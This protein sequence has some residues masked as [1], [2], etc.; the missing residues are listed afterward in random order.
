MLRAHLRA[1]PDADAHAGEYRSGVLGFTGGL[2]AAVVAAGGAGG[3]GASAELPLAFEANGG[4]YE[5]QVR[6]VGRDAG[7]VVAL[8]DRGADVGLAAGG[9]VALR[10]AGARR[11]VRVLGAGRRQG[12]V[13]D[14]RAGRTGIPAWS[15]VRFRRPWRGIDVVFHGRRKTLEYDIEVAPHADPRDA[16]I[17]VSG[18][19]PVV[20]PDGSLAIRTGHGTLVQRAPVAWQ[21]ERRV[22]VRYVVR[23]R[24]LGFAVG[25]YD[26]SRRLVI[27]PVVQY[28]TYLGGTGFDTADGLAVDATGAAYV[29]GTTATPDWLGLAPGQDTQ[30]GGRDIVLTKLAPAGTARVY[31]TLLGGTED[32]AG[33]GL[34][35]RSVPGPSGAEIQPVLVGST[36]SG[37]SFPGAPDPATPAGPHGFV[38]ALRAD[39]TSVASSRLV[40]SEYGATDLS[41][42][43]V[44]SDGTTV[45][46]AGTT[47]APTL[48]GATGTLSGPS[49]AVVLRLTAA[50]LAATPAAFA[51]LGGTGEDL[52][53]GVTAL[54]D[55]TVVAGQSTSPTLPG[56]TPGSFD[57]TRGGAQDGFVLRLSGTTPT[58]TFLGGA[59]DGDALHDLVAD[60]TGITVVG[61]TGSDGLATPG[62]ADGTLDGS[63]DGVVARLAADLSS[64]AW[65]TYVGGPFA[66]DAYGIARGAAGGYWVAGREE[67]ERA[68]D[69]L[70]VREPHAR[71]W[72]L[73]GDGTAVTRTIDVGGRD[74]F[75]VAHH[76]DT[77]PAGNAYVAGTTVNGGDATPGAP[78]SEVQGSDDLFLAKLDGAAPQTSITD[79]PAGEVQASSVTFTFTADEPATFRCSLD[80]ADLGPC[81]S[82]KQVTVQPG[83]HV[84]AVTATDEAG[85]ADATPAERGFTATVAPEP[86][87]AP[88]PGA[89][90][91]STPPG[92]SLVLPFAAVLRD[93]RG[94]VP[95][96]PLVL[97]ASASTGTPPLRFSWDLDGDGAFE[98]GPQEDPRRQHVF[99]EPGDRRVSVRVT[100]AS[101]RVT[102]ASALVTVARRLRMTPKLDVKGRR[103]DFA[104]G[105]TTDP[106]FPV[107]HYVYDFGDGSAPRTDRV[108][109]GGIAF[110]NVD[111]GRDATPSHRYAKDGLYRWSITAV[112]TNGDRH[113]VSGGVEVETGRPKDRTGG[114][115]LGS[116]LKKNTMWVA[117]DG[118]PDFGGGDIIVAG[119]DPVEYRLEGAPARTT[120]IQVDRNTP[121]R[122]VTV[123]GGEGFWNMGDGSPVKTGF[124]VLHTYKTKKDP[125]QVGS[126]K[127][128]ASARASAKKQTPVPATLPF[129]PV[130]RGVVHFKPAAYEKTIEEAIVPFAVRPLAAV[131]T[132]LRLAGDATARGA[133][134]SCLYPSG[135]GLYRTAAGASLLVNGLEVRPAEADGRIW[136]S[137]D[138]TIGKDKSTRFDVIADPTPK[139]GVAG[140]TIARGLSRFTIPGPGSGLREVHGLTGPPSSGENIR[141]GGLRVG[142]RTVQVT[143]KGRMRTTLHSILPA[144]FGAE[145]APITFDTA[146]QTVAGGSIHAK[147]GQPIEVV[148][149]DMTFG[150][151]RAY[152]ILL[153]LSAEHVLEGGG[154]LEIFENKILAPHAKPDETKQVDIGGG[155][156][157]TL[158]GPSGFAVD[159]GIRDDSAP[160]APKFLYGGATFVPKKPI[161][162]GP[163]GVSRIVLGVQTDPFFLKGQITAEAPIS[164]PI[165][166][167]DGCVQIQKVEKGQRLLLC[168]GDVETLEECAQR[169]DDRANNR[170]LPETSQ[171]FFTLYD[172][173]EPELA[174]ALGRA[175][176]P[177]EVCAS[178]ASTSD[179][180]QF[181]LRIGAEVF[182]K[183]G[184][185]S[186]G[187]GFFEYRSGGGGSVHFGGYANASFPGLSLKGSVEGDFYFE[188]KF[189]WQIFA[190]I[191]A[192]ILGV[193]AGAQVIV[194]NDLIAAC[195]DVDLLLTEAAIGGGVRWDSGF[196]GIGGF[197]QCD[198]KT[199]YGIQPKAT[200]ASAETM[201]RQGTQPMGRSQ[202]VKSVRG[203]PDYVVFRVDAAN[204]TLPRIKVTG[205][206]FEA[207]DPGPSGAPGARSLAAAG[208]GRVKFLHFER[209]A[210]PG[211]APA[212]VVAIARP[213]AGDYTIT[214]LPEG[215]AIG[216]VSQSTPIP[217]PKVTAKV[218][219]RGNGVFE[220]RTTVPKPQRGEAP[221]K[222]AIVEDARTPKEIRQPVTPSGAQI[223]PSAG[224]T[225]LDTRSDATAEIV[226]NAGYGT[227]SHFFKP[228][229]G[230]GGTRHLYA[231]IVR[232]DTPLPRMPLGSYAAPAP[233]A[234]RAPQDAELVRK[235]SRLE[236]DWTDVPDAAQYVVTVERGDGAVRSYTL[237]GRPATRKKVS[238][239]RRTARARTAAKQ[240]G[241]KTGGKQVTL[242]V[243]ED[244]VKGLRSRLTVKGVP[245]SEDVTVRIRAVDVH[246]RESVPELVKAGPIEVAP[247]PIAG[248]GGGTKPPIGP[249]KGV[250]GT[251]P[252]GQL[253][254]PSN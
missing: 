54:G 102:D 236:I 231:V 145:T 143:G 205:P 185:M 160:V 37:A 173:Q 64:R 216:A 175:P 203:K 177:E 73:L 224:G 222:V 14:L 41:A 147:L 123:K 10:L 30:P 9:R 53:F 24:E 21:G 129:D 130:Y 106:R 19:R 238:I 86:P 171:P 172:T 55:D 40:A 196:F 189:L 233:P 95:N 28:Q 3:T 27:D 249:V 245:E 34:A 61:T 161:A 176:K 188:P 87:P 107:D 232:G 125:K 215:G 49:D 29:L 246:L 35:L 168:K 96:E 57:S 62:A 226:A 116:T 38:L 18:G 78:Q 184:K 82:P 239:G 223:L 83:G 179:Y 244:V 33:G 197:E 101:G 210:A 2:I 84:F 104:L 23:G 135:D 181:W 94:A 112:A 158:S 243:A 32:D 81:T 211:E 159:T 220:L 192:N 77:D 234:V 7:S 56:M 149:P 230:P 170:P 25:P 164:A 193:E 186:L 121:P 13:H 92:P 75:D 208:G 240:T 200:L 180:D 214:A 237:R 59:A 12:V 1:S 133:A 118:D 42:V 138:G 5:E 191:E 227:R 228:A 187:G 72:R 150:P 44:G 204:G 151:V 144:P 80:G 126:S 89:P 4:R 198:L 142:G 52:A 103:V 110:R 98:V 97:D 134:G 167:L 219:P 65:A 58:S 169:I 124:S 128:V 74:G 182:L 252:A 218:I 15:R 47:S 20:R 108:R 99:A 105:T 163:V 199:D 17:R 26:R 113:T 229:H 50:D 235:G 71:A 111:V 140:Q 248:Y 155:K 119:D 225:K 250:P 136:V 154:F 39:G 148:L 174:K 247:V 115:A 139:D 166:D 183:G 241:A 31:S 22:P 63:R 202:A 16:R 51:L 114:V 195:I 207:V 120:T 43:A 60:A 90:P 76:V 146:D 66:D 213:A 88:T 153:E 45:H 36:A 79:G 100:D 190:N 221:L 254:A 201:L 117:T 162:L 165:V 70:P 152:D 132:G 141:L 217:D 127:G 6:F 91:A 8:H 46:V 242:T 137:V 109:K 122:S 69:S 253:V 251:V 48:P 209:P 93:V 68:V 157:Y 194:N 67:L 11:D 131:C 156:T 212:V 178:L 85:N 206:R